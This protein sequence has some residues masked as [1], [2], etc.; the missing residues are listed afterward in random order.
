MR[1]SDMAILQGEA[2]RK[3]VEDLRLEQQKRVVKILAQRKR[4]A[5][6]SE[7]ELFNYE[8]LISLVDIST[9]ASGAILEDRKANLEY[10]YYVEKVSLKNIEEFANYISRI[11]EW[12]ER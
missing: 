1:L 4:E 11:N 2:A 7:K 9:Y 12:A 5:L 10:G 8:K 3:F 6:E